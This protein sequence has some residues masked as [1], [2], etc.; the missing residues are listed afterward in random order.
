M[1]YPTAGPRP[2]TL[3]WVPAGQAGENIQ[4]RDNLDKQGTGEEGEWVAKGTRKPG[5]GAEQKRDRSNLPFSKRFLWAEW[6][7]TSWGEMEAG[8][9]VW[10]V[11][12][13]Q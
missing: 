8:N 5:K 2:P 4:G 11:R 6:R 1:S 9:P 13:A 12:E 7:V 10:S 3:S